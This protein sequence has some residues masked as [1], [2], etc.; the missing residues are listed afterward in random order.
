MFDDLLQYSQDCQIKALLSSSAVFASD[1]D[2]D[3]ARSAKRQI[4]CL[5]QWGKVTSPLCP[6]RRTCSRI[7]VVRTHPYLPQALRSDMSCQSEG[8]CSGWAS[9][10]SMQHSRTSR[11]EACESWIPHWLYRPGHLYA[12]LYSREA[13]ALRSVSGLSQKNPS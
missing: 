2:H 13:V 10:F 4:S 7:L 1:N 5:R 6:R 12:G 3:C 8:L 9:S 11:I